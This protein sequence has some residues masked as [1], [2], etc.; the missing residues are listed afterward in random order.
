[1]ACADKPVCC[2]ESLALQFL[3][4]TKARRAD[5]IQQIAKLALLVFF[6]K[7]VAVAKTKETKHLHELGLPGRAFPGINVPNGEEEEVL[8]TPHGHLPPRVTAAALPGHSSFRV[9]R[10]EFCGGGQKCLDIFWEQ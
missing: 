8:A 1:M 7:R 5:V 3:P 2:P 10:D 4:K 9:G 6:A